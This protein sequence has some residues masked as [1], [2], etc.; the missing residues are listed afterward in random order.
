MV[1]HGSRAHGS[2]LIEV[3][4]SADR[5]VR[6]LPLE[7]FCRTAT[8]PELL[9][10]CQALDTFRRRCD[11]LYERVRATFFLYAIHRF[12]LP[13]AAANGADGFALAGAIPYRGYEYLL[14]RRFEE[15]IDTFLASQAAQGPSDGLSS[16][17]AVAYHQ[18]G[19]QTLADQVRRSVRSVRGNQW[20]FRMGHPAD[21]PLRIRPELLRADDVTGLYPLLREST[22]VRMDLS[23]SGWS[24]IFF[25]G[26][27][28]PEGARVLNVSIDLAVRGRDERPAPPV[29]AYLRVIDEPV[30]RLVSVDLATQADVTSL[31]E[32]FDFARDYLGLLKAALIAAGIVPS[33]I[34]GGQQPLEDLLARVVGPGRGLELVSHVRG[35]PRGSR[36]AVS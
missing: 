13:A 32:V 33:G 30:L 3:I 15:A 23:H 6:D 5:A 29:E 21:H 20:M 25:L 28:Y 17:L 16:A 1:A 9:A 4:T 8:L 27:D 14:E 12:H 2:R 19:F 24:D 31:G 7:R 22:P 35:I 26:M 36:L 11:N 18:L 10:E 34:E